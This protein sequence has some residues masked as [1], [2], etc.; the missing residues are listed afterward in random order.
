MQC[1]R[2][3]LGIVVVLVVCLPYVISAQNQSPTQQKPQAQSSKKPV[4]KKPGPKLTAEQQRGL[5]IL[6]SVQAE[7]AGLE[8]A[9]Q[10][11]V[12]WQVSHGYRKARPKKAD[13]VLLRAFTASRRI[14]DQ[15]FAEECGGLEQVSH[16]Q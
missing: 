1:S 5:R 7:A 14:Q 11:Y 13:A 3:W 4:A 10:T 8:P 12:L 9:M 15:N 16:V 6:K 2:M